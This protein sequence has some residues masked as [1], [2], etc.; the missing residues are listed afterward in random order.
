MSRMRAE[1]FW[2]VWA[3]ALLLVLA[4]LAFGPAAVPRSGAAAASF[5]LVRPL[6]AQEV[7]IGGGD[8]MCTSAA[9]G[10]VLYCWTIT[11]GAGSPVIKWYG[12]LKVPNT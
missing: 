8:L 10:T 12:A 5:S 3:T 2:R 11:R 6:Q 4:K 9:A 1:W 7:A